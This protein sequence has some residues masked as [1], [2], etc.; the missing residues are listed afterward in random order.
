[1]VDLVNMG[2]H[3]F[4]KRIIF[5]RTYQNASCIINRNHMNTDFETMLE[6]HDLYPLSFSDY[7]R[8]GGLSV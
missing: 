6:L 3:C 1:M 5:K 8:N 2:E 4:Y 7:A